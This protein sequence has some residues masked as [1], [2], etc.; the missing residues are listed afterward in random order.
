MMIYRCTKSHSVL[1][2]CWN[3][4]ASFYCCRTSITQSMHLLHATLVLFLKHSSHLAP[5]RHCT[6]IPC[7]WTCS[8]YFYWPLNPNPI[9]DS[10]HIRSWGILETPISLLAPHPKSK[11][12]PH[13]ML[14]T[15]ILFYCHTIY[16]KI[17]D[18]NADQLLNPSWNTWMQKKSR[19]IFKRPQNFRFFILLVASL[20]SIVLSLV[21]RT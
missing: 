7:S 16:Y 17:A 14:C 15:Q 5:D 19:L 1:S 4:N 18:P 21:N 9:V 3:S 20:V 6:F 8:F 11:K 2:N 13:F 12:I 10:F